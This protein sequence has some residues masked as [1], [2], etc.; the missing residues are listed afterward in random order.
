ML[1]PVE[2]QDVSERFGGEIAA[3]RRF[4]SQAAVPL[5]TEQAVRETAKRIVEDSGFR[6]D[7]K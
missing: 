5:G 7:L 1:Q 2:L 4:L 3:L 6:R